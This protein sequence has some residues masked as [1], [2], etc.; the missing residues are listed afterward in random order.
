MKT[1]TSVCKTLA[2]C[3]LSGIRRSSL[4]CSVP[5]S[6]NKTRPFICEWSVASAL[7]A[8]TGRPNPIGPVRR[9]HRVTQTQK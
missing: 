8:Q 1:Y 5:D 4:Q 2:Y 9:V 7:L 6:R 3:A